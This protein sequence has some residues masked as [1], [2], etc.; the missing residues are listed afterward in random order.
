MRKRSD[1]Q[2]WRSDK[3]SI[4]GV[5][6]FDLAKYASPGNEDK[7][8][9]DKLILKNCLMDPEGTSYVE[10]HIRCKIEGGAMTPVSGALPSTP[11]S[12]RGGL[13]SSSFLKMPTIEEKESEH[14]LKE[15]IER[16]EKNY[17]KKLD[18]LEQELDKLNKLKEQQ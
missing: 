13:N 8:I 9:E 17:L 2:V 6:E 12:M 11:N 4:I 3:S 7:M 5:A 15:E 10:I 18:E 14:D 16:K 1:L